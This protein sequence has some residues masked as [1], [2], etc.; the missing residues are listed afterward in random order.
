MAYDAIAR[1]YT[2][3]VAGRTQTFS[4][5]SAESATTVQYDVANGATTDSLT[6]TKPG[7][8]GTLT[9]QYVGGG[10]WQ[11]QVS[12]S[13]S[14]SGSFDAFT[15]GVTTPSTGMPR[16]GAAVYDI[17]LIGTLATAFRLEPIALAGSGAMTADFATGMASLSGPISGINTV[18]G[19]TEFRSGF[20]G[21]GSIGTGNGA[22]AGTFT[23]FGMSG[24]IGELNGRFYGP[25]ANEFGAVFTTR[26]GSS[27]GVSGPGGDVAVGAIIGRQGALGGS[28]RLDTLT[29]PQTFSSNNV[30]YA[31]YVR[32]T[33]TQLPAEYVSVTQ[34]APFSVTYTPAT[35]GLELNGN[36]QR[37]DASLDGRSFSRVETN[38]TNLNFSQSDIVAAES[39]SRFTVY[40]KTDGARTLRLLA[41]APGAGNGELALSYASFLDLQIRDT[42]VAAGKELATRVYLPYGALTPATQMPR[43]GAATYN[44][45][46]YA[47]ATPVSGGSP[48]SDRVA[49]SIYDVTGTVNFTANFVDNSLRGGMTLTG[50][51]TL[52]GL[53]RDFDTL[54]L[55]GNISGSTFTLYANQLFSDHGVTGSALGAFYGP[56]ANEAAGQTILNYSYVSNPSKDVNIVG[57][58]VAKR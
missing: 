22:F 1:S 46:V 56:V 55:N 9:Y 35:R 31:A 48:F 57:V 19:I 16:T 32:N 54:T 8:T 42:S 40:Q 24:M 13:S 15:Y 34:G 29:A 49:T 44:G 26:A 7:T 27:V 38:L 58:F 21:G 30:A 25:S 47:T 28:T 11:R 3:S 6:L 14:V 10:F 43:V 12:G 52:T 5:K 41:Y 45:N 36:G 50:R 2:V 37:I 53:M 33:A 18:S 4:S 51:E 23:F 17:A 20:A 39:N